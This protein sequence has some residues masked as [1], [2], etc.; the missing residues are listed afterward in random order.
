MHCILKRTDLVL[1]LG[2]PFLPDAN[3]GSANWPRRK[4]N[5]SIQLSTQQVPSLY[6]PAGPVGVDALLA[7]HWAV[8]Y[9]PVERW[10]ELYSW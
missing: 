9:K 4:C 5:L 1:L 10:P 2:A 8:K 6:M 7:E 3:T